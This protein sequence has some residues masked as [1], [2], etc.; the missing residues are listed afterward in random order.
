MCC[1]QCLAKSGEL[2]M[3]GAATESAV[4]SALLESTVPLARMEQGCQAFPWVL[5]EC[6]SPPGLALN[7]LHHA[8]KGWTT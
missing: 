5:N 2:V 4:P 6:Q 8:H 1:S 3:R 7:A